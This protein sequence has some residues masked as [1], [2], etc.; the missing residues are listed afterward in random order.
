MFHTEVLLGSNFILFLLDELIHPC[1]QCFHSG[2]G[3][4]HKFP[5][6]VVSWKQGHFEAHDGQSV[7]CIFDL[8]VN[9]LESF[10]EFCD[11][12]TLFHPYRHQIII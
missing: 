1:H 6:E 4:S 2:H 10:C 5:P 12:L 7:I 3:V 8:A 11:V 9:G